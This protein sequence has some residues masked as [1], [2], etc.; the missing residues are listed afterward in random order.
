MNRTSLA[1]LAALA[2]LGA[3]AAPRADRPALAAAAVAPVEVKI[4]AF[5]D[6]HGNLP[7][8]RQAIPARLPD[9]GEVR[10]PA[11]G[12]A[13]F[14]SAVAALKAENPNH[15]VVSAGDMISASPF[16]SALFL[17]EPTIHAM[18]AIGIDFNALGNHE[19]DRGRAEI[20][21]MQNGG[22]EVHT[23]RTPCAVEPYE[24]AR[25]GF[26]AA[27]TLTEDGTTLFP[28]WGMRSFGSGAGEVK[29]AFVGMTLKETPTVVSPSGVAGLTFADEADTVNALVPRLKA[30]G[31]DAIVVLI[32][33]GLVTSAPYVDKSCAVEG[34]LKP[35]LDRLDPAVDLVVSGHTHN[36]YVCD[37]AKVDPA[38]AF[39]VTS[40]G[41]YGTMLTDITL[42][43]DP[44]AGRVVSRRA[45]NRIVQNDGYPT[46]AGE[47]APQP[48]FA[49]FAADPQVAA[50]VDRYAEAARESERKVV[51]RLTAP[52]PR[53]RDANGEMVLG[54]L[55]ADAQLHAARESGAEI[56]FMN[57]G[58]VRAEIAPADGQVTFGHLFAAQPFGNGLVV[59]G[60]TGRQIRAILEQQFASGL[61]SVEQPNVLLVSE[62]FSYGYDLS[63]PEGQRIL[64]PRLGGR[65]LEDDRVYRVAISSFLASGGDNFTLFREG[66]EQGTGL[67][68]LEAL[69]AYFRARNP[70][71]PPTPGRVRNLTPR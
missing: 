24:G 21:R 45:D 23:S 53:D 59:K 67:Q 60:F 15:V 31:A 63:R 12:A 44:V 20:L 14:A 43:I 40:A 29:V 9:G 1:A 57:A 32:H 42:S 30:E 51:G 16:V 10:V 2:A 65:P 50:I 61:N 11:G 36:A 18:N 46:S 58:G 41:Q 6:F 26:L 39:L 19:F 47:V 56:A 35:I 66:P 5:N 69:E 7:V 4:I 34:D 70:L 37:Y 28:A 25:F 17:D 49:R 52:A 8:P 54:M 22:C 3:C 71:T 62:G 68:D 38:R 48:A 64:D 55:I 33:Q 27:N 13:Y